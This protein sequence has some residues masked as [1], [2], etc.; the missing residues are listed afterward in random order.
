V[1][2]AEIFGAGTYF[3][4]TGAHPPDDVFVSGGAHLSGTVDE[5]QIVWG[6]LCDSARRHLSPAPKYFIF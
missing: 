5:P 2:Y 3:G 4:G 6:N 1:K